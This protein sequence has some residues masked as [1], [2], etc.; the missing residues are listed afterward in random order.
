VLL[1]V[2]QVELLV[3]CID[4]VEFAVPHYVSNLCIGLHLCSWSADYIAQYSC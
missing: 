1:L 4:T 3:A 2:A